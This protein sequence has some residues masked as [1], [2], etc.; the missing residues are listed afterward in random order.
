MQPPQ[1]PD[2]VVIDTDGTVLLRREVA[3][4]DAEEVPEGLQVAKRPPRVVF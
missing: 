2:Y 1:R 3:H 4:D